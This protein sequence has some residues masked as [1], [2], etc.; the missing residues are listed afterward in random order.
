MTA[1]PLPLFP[2]STVLFPGGILPLRVFEARYM[3]MI[4]TAMRDGSAFGIVMI[5]SGLEAGDRDV[6]IE[7]VG[8]R[9]RIDTWDMAQLGVLEIATTG[10]TRFRIL[11]H[12]VR[13]DGLMVANVVDVAE[14]S[15]VDIP[16]D[17]RR[18][19]TLLER[20]VERM[21]ASDDAPVSIAKP[22]RFDSA[23]WVGNRLAEVLPIPL[24]AKQ[25]LMAMTDASTRLAILSELLDEYG[26]EEAT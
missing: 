9:A 16:A 19:I 3:D 10:T 15:P 22:Y 14:E 7:E 11:D 23:T 21:D 26:L 13:S 25:H 4:R 20:I 2:L 17:I 6:E 12:E 5:R 18:G 24:P 1:T 8:C